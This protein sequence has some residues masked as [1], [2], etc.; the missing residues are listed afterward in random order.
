MSI[1]AN[2]LP[3]RAWAHPGQETRG[4]KRFPCG[5]NSKVLHRECSEGDSGD[6]DSCPVRQKEGPF[7]RCA[8]ENTRAIFPMCLQAEKRNMAAR[9]ETATLLC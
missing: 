8:S 7:V 2:F 6:S 3:E 1:S 4:N 9:P 5:A